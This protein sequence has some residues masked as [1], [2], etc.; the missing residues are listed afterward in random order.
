MARFK[1][2]IGKVSNKRIPGRD[3]GNEP[4]IFLNN[5]VS[6]SGVDDSQSEVEGRRNPQKGNLVQNPARKCNHN[7]EPSQRGFNDRLQDYE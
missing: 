5:E 4:T 1:R 3:A 6:S 7:K 2:Y